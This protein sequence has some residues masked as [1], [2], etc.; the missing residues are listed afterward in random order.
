MVAPPKSLLGLGASL[1]TLRTAQRLRRAGSA[2]AEQDRA[3]RS[4][5]GNLARTAYGRAAGIAAR[6]TYGQFQAQVPLRD[7]AQFAP[8]IERMKQAEEDVLWPGRCDYFARTPG[9]SAAP[10]HLPVTRAMIGHFRQAGMLAVLHY[11]ARVG[12]AGVFHGRHLLLGG[13]CVLDRLESGGWLGDISGIARRHLP[14]WFRQDLVEPDPDTAEM[15]DWSAKIRATAER[16]RQRDIT[17]IAAM[18]N[19]LLLL[20]RAL[21]EP[22]GSSKAA[23]HL[24][25]I[26]PN[27]ECVIHGGIPIGPFADELR[28]AIGPD[29]ALHEVFATAEGVFAA[30][31]G[32]A[33]AGLRVMSDAGIFLEFLP[34]PEYDEGR[35][36]NLGRRTV[37]LEGVRP[38]VDYVLVVTA[39]S[40]L[41]RYVPGDVV[42][43][44]STE[45]PRL[46]HIG[47]VDLRLTTFGEQVSEK[48]LTDALITVCQRHHWRIV[49]FHVAPFF[50]NRTTGQIRGRHEWWVE[51][52][53]GTVDTPTGPA[54]ASELDAEL[55]RLHS[56]YRE[57]RRSRAM[58]APFLRLVMPGL[59][60][61]WLQRAGK[62]DGMHKMP[63]CRDDRTVADQ[64]EKLAP[65]AAH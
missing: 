45:P 44:L 23:P 50:I 32:N 54:M 51:L 37:P 6:M 3:R 63:R 9:V 25:A 19:W 33:G 34:L 24:Q 38:H 46:I 62:W 14:D 29:V 21:L 36:E 56:T 12:H 55:Q 61:E 52:R 4:L 35:L 41:C 48:D 57:R 65:F 49:N 16:T 53:P 39:P 15:T 26:W 2:P 20:A 64:L 28:H 59:F 27:L 60:D 8:W 7:H 58:E 30:Q 5:L 47:N 40:G 43:F 18:P 1:L 22:D 17:L 13:S 31:D 42:R 10:K 11:T